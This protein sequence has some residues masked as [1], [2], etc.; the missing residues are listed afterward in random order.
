MC[1]HMYV[2]IL[3]YTYVIRSYSYACINI[4]R[5]NKIYAKA[6]TITTSNNWGMKNV[7]ILLLQV[8]CSQVG[9]TLHAMHGH[10]YMYMYMLQLHIYV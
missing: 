3:P 7:C 5:V 1:V 9:C 2:H 6:C 8:Y 10:V 4:S